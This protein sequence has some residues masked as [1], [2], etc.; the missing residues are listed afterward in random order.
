MFS[1]VNEVWNNDP[2]KEM[3]KK[4]SNGDFQV[5]GGYLGS[6][7]IPNLSDDNSLSILSE[8]TLGLSAFNSEYTPYAPVNNS[9]DKYLKSS[10]TNQKK[11][12]NNGK[13]LLS[14]TFES[15][16]SLDN[17]KNDTK[18][19]CN[20]SINHL[21]NCNRCYDKLKR[22][23]NSQLN[24]KFDEIILDTK[25]KQLQHMTPLQVQT[26]AAE[27][28]SNNSLMTNSW[29]DVALIVMAIVIIIFFIL[30]IFKSSK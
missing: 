11:S 27:K 14:E 9:F 30:F 29:K 12:K 7:S 17:N 6:K 18:S 1:S 20:Y 15:D 8:N 13:H 3:T 21:K 10:K 22:L 5:M 19:K 23:V 2:V 28:V 16:F 4:L 24:E 26:Q 25:M